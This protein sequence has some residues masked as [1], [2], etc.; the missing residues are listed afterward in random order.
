MNIIQ[1]TNVPPFG[2]EE[3]SRQLRASM[4][5]GKN[6]SPRLQ[7]FMTQVGGASLT[8]HQAKAVH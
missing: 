3:C 1:N 2:G 7:L 4:A 6:S 5:P 8:N